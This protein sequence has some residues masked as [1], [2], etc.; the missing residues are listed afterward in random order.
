MSNNHYIKKALK[1]FA[2]LEE[3]KVP[4]DQVPSHVADIKYFTNQSGITD[5]GELSPGK[6]AKEV[7]A[8]MT[9][10]LGY[11]E[12]YVAMQDAKASLMT[13]KIN[14]DTHYDP[15]PARI[16]PVFKAA[17]IDITPLFSN[18]KKPFRDEVDEVV[19]KAEAALIAEYQARSK[20]GVGRAI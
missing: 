20:S 7:E 15:D 10:A 5:I 17:G 1:E 18:D 16:V 9:A 11:A 6:T 19:K 12:R 14:G 2:R 3:G 4:L 13:R 8:I